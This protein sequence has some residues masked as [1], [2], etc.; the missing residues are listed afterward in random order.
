[1]DFL[2]LREVLLIEYNGGGLTPTGRVF[3]T[4]LENNAE[5]K[6]EM[7]FYILNC[8]LKMKKIRRNVQ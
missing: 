2:G 3:F 7:W 8:T 4:I 1:V 6:C 5:N